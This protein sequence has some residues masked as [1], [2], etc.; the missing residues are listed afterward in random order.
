MAV[1]TDIANMYRR[2]KAVVQRILSQGNREEFALVILMGACLI[3]CFAQLPRLARI[4]YL[5]GGSLERDLIYVFFVWMM[6][7]PLM[8][9]GVAAISHIIA[10]VFRGRGT[11]LG[12]RL[13]LFW[14]L[15]AA[16]PVMILWGLV[17]GFIGPSPALSISGALWLAAFLLFWG[18]G[19]K[20]A[21]WP[22]SESPA[23]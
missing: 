19:M 20:L 1:T 7:A 5:E 13:A 9:Y 21:E 10:K 6:I 18:L 17:A 14:A 2:P 8:L 23:S 3:I 11:W 22:N 12:S 15:L 16:A 4:S